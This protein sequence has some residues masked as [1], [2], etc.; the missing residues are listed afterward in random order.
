MS[1]SLKNFSSRSPK[2]IIAYGRAIF[3][4]IAFPL[5]SLQNKRLCSKILFFKMNS[6][7]SIRDSVEII[8]SFRK[9]RA[10]IN[11]SLCGILGYRP[12]ASMVHSI[13]SSGKGGRLANLQKKS[14]VSLMYN[15]T[16]W[17]SGLRW[18]SVKK[19]IFY[20]ENPDFE[21]TGLPDTSFVDL[22]K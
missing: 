11:P 17:A 2:K 1:R 5:S 19:K 20:V 21:I 6:A 16:F 9:S 12:T 8:L 10:A 4:A 22:R 15:L 7:N 3:E 18:Y 13:T 14:F